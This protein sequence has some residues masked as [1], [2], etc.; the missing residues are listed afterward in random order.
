MAIKRRSTMSLLVP[1]GYGTY[2]IMGIDPGL[3]N[4]GVA[5]ATI[6]AYTDTIREIEAYTLCNDK[7]ADRTGLESDIHPDR[8]IKLFK[9]RKAIE[10]GLAWATPM[11]VG[12]EAPFYNRLRPM[13]YGAL[14]EVVG[15]IQ[16]AVLQSNTNTGFITFPPLTVKK[17]VGARSIKNDTEKGK[18]EVSEAVSRIPEIM[19]VLRQDL[20]MLTEHAIDA[21]AVT[22]T[23]HQYLKGNLRV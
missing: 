15:M 4:T 17:I 18:I 13:A 10:E 20:S 1:E 23:L 5:I 12:C 3:T 2:R 8:I 21:I 7:L 6:D 14:V 22:Y 9:L 16:T 19:Q 11:I